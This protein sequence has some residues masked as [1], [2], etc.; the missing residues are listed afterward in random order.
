[1]AEALSAIQKAVQAK[2]IPPCYVIQAD[3]K[4]DDAGNFFFNFYKQVLKVDV[5]TEQ[6]TKPRA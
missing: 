3:M 4:R 6:L 1:L 2:Q 5:V